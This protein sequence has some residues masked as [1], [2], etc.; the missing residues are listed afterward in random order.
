MPNIDKLAIELALAKTREEKKKLAKAILEKGYEKGVYPWSINDLYMARAKDGFGGFTVPAIN[1][2][3]M[4]YE[5]ARAIFRTAKKIDAGTFILEIAKSEMGYTGQIPSEYVSMCVAAAVREEFSGPIFIQG[6]HFQLNAKKYKENPEKEV[7]G[8]RDLI[9]EAVSAG[10]YNI[11]IDSSTLV[12]LSKPTTKEEQL[13]NYKVCA[14]LTKFIR[15]IE[16]EGLSVSIGGEIGEVGGKNSTPDELRVY[17]HGYRELIGKDMTGI[18]KISI[19]TGTSHG[20]VVLADG[21]VAKVKLDFETLRNLSKLA[22]DEFGMAGAVQHGASTL[23][24][25]AFGKFPE[26]E[27]AEVH[28]ATQFQNIVYDSKNFPKD[29]KEKIYSWISKNLSAEK[30]DGQTEEQFIYKTRKKALGPFKADI[31]NMPKAAKEKIVAEVEK[32]FQFLFGKLNIK[33]TKEIVSKYFKPKA[34]QARI[35]GELAAL[36]MDGEGDD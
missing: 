6:D 5:L 33:G 12:D 23:P 28:L 36:E 18:S 32:E 11:D 10:F 2:R 1:I 8:I 13:H 15:E 26:V 30:K 22:R 21:T 35:K 25:D 7:Q 3:T 17:M 20:G 4:T 14:E 31:I 19:Q 9:T 34:V 29:L 16:P 27:A 24:N